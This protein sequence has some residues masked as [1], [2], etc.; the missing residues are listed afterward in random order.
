MNL[1]DKYFDKYKATPKGVPEDEFAKINYPVVQ[2]YGKIC[3]LEARK[4]CL[5][6]NQSRLP[7]D[8]YIA[9][10]EKVVNELQEIAE[11]E[12]L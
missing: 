1:S 12:N 6:E 3:A 9:E 11:K 10:L 2:T 8:Y 4:T 7:N 5:V